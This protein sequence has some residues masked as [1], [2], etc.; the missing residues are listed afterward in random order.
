[1]ADILPINLD[2]ESYDELVEEVEILTP[3]YLLA[4]E[5]LEKSEG[6]QKTHECL[7]QVTAYWERLSLL[8]D[9]L[10]EIPWSKAF[11]PSFSEMRMR[12]LQNELEVLEGI[13]LPMH[14]Q[15][16]F[17]KPQDLAPMTWEVASC[18]LHRMDQI[19]DGQGFVDSH[20]DRCFVRKVLRGNAARRDHLEKAVSRSL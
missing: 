15:I 13:Y 17:S 19:L 5:S 16:Y 4:L 7:Q 6:L 11:D 18:V 10:E 8:F 20:K 1:M 12:A 3:K 2:Y 9:E 14:R